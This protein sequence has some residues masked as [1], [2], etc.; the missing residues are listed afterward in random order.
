MQFFEG[1]DDDE[2]DDCDPFMCEG[3]TD[4]ENSPRNRSTE[5]RIQLQEAESQDRIDHE[6]SQKFKAQ[7]TIDESSLEARI[8]SINSISRELRPLGKVVAILNS[9]NREKE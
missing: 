1:H 3:Y 4:N 6:A 5:R 9:P 8:A 7:F 2:D